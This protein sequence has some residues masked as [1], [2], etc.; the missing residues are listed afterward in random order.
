LDLRLKISLFGPFD[1]EMAGQ[2]LPPLRSVKGQYLLAL[3]AL[4]HNRDVSRLW[5]AET[6]WPDSLQAEA[7]GSLR[8]SLADLRRA[9]GTEAER[10][11]SPMRTLLRMEASGAEIDTIAFDAAVKRGGAEGWKQ[12]VALYRGPLLEGA[13]EPWILGERSMRQQAYLKALENLAAL[14]RVEGDVTSEIAYQRRIVAC[15]PLREG[16]Q[17]A[18]MQV[19]ARSGEVQA[20][21]DTYQDMRRRLHQEQ[22]AQPTPETR[23]IY[24]Q[25]R[26]QARKEAGQQAGQ[27]GSGVAPTA[28]RSG[29]A[30]GNAERRP[31][32]VPLPL[33]S[34][35]GREEALRDIKA[36]LF[37]SRLV[38]LVGTGG[39]GK[40][41]LAAQ[42]ANE[43]REDFEDGTW[44][45]DL[46]LFVS[47]V[48]VERVAQEMAGLLGVAEQ[49]GRSRLQTLQDTLR[50][51]QILFVL[52][53]CETLLDVGRQLAQ[54]LLQTCP[55]VRLLVTSRQRLGMTSET[56]LPVVPLVLPVTEG[57]A[58]MERLDAPAPR[59]FVERA[60]AVHPSF[61][62]DR[63]NAPAIIEICRR[64]DG[65]PLA[66]ELAA[67]LCDVLT[68]GEIAARLN[69]RFALLG[70]Q[71]RARPPRHQTL[72]AV[73]E[74]SAALLSS[75]EQTLL[76]RLSVFVGGWTLEAAEAVGEG[77]DSLFPSLFA[78]LR[79]LVS[80]S[81]VVAEEQGGQMRY[82]LLESLREYAGEELARAGEADALRVRHLAYYARFACHAEPELTGPQQAAWLENLEAETGNLRSALEWAEGR[83]DDQTQ[84]LR[85]A[86]AL[87]RYWQIRGHFAEGR[88]H[89]LRLLNASETLSAPTIR[90]NALNWAGL[91][92]VFHGDFITAQTLCEQAVALWKSVG[93]EAGA[94]GSLGILGI[95]AANRGELDEARRLYG[96]ALERARAAGDRPGV[97]GTLG[98]LGIVAVSQGYYEEARAYYEKSLA[99]RRELGDVWGIGA[100]L[101]NLGLLARRRGDLELAR[102]L[103]HQTLAIRRDLRDRRSMGITL[104][105]LAHVAWQQGDLQTAAAYQAEAQV[106]FVRIGDQRSIAYGLEM[107]ARLAVS[108]GQPE[109]AARLCSAA[110]QLRE[111]LGAP[112]PSSEQQELDRDLQPAMLHLG[113]MAWHAAR[114]EERIPDGGK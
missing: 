80:K 26:R 96:Q 36:A 90:A 107:G 37:T 69:D 102:D 103:L 105:V 67:A 51:R 34:L 101:N 87:G 55:N 29:G 111:E 24:E 8:Q 31:G 43:L 91:L 85:L 4:R 30:A 58:D 25:I 40:T 100:S 64:L 70:E 5:I 71:E 89:L 60:Q 9:L 72:R 11:Q 62:P 57:A 74:S 79:S 21:L 32:N 19:L 109:L 7:L 106:L 88:Q 22:G 53:N 108:E 63:D 48:T 1:V 86:G 76:R 84:G 42:A 28:P 45:V 33:S 12:A 99:L 3:L 10:L 39:V 97:A 59:L 92:S 66:L 46:S 112:L 81:L 94:A 65:L 61:L 82:R 16:A 114:T 54:A 14:A 104:N 38:T 35:I 56:V 41:R 20:A 93:D 47:A 17:R 49:P 78:S 83:K 2:P 73:I 98:Y 95:V 50:T 18:L 52:D 27:Q 68:P 23:A 44:F 13:S 15:D 75:T 113:A 6:L 110:R 77:T